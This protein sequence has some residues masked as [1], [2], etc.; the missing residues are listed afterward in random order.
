M[1]NRAT[2]RLQ[3]KKRHLCFPF[4]TFFFFGLVFSERI[5]VSDHTRF[6]GLLG[7]CS[8]HTALFS[9]R[10]SL[11]FVVFNPQIMALELQGDTFVLEWCW[12]LLFG[13]CFYNCLVMFVGLFFFNT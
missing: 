13:S 1:R 3:N 12:I 6:S 2:P 11:F 10:L 8:G 9:C 7:Q 4:W 5:I